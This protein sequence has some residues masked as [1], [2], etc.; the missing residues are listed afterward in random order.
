MTSKTDTIVP[1]L[2]DPILEKILWF[3]YTWGV[4]EHYKFA[5]KRHII[6]DP[7]C[8]CTRHSLWYS[9]SVYRCLKYFFV[10]CF[11]RDL[12]IKT[13]LDLIFQVAEGM[14]FL[15]DKNF[16]HRDLAAR[17]VLLVNDHFAKISDF[18]MS[19]ALGLGNEY[20]KVR[21]N[22]Y[23]CICLFPPFAVLIPKNGQPMN[24][25][26]LQAW[27]MQIVILQCQSPSDVG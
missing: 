22:L 13:V 5:G 15:E 7:N 25:W 19:K 11:R 18:G 21:F 4:I 23:F 27:I 16:V 6:R 26:Y 3:L 1:P 24:C 8:L 20:Y 14:A 10:P 9:I 2:F 17:N 12:P